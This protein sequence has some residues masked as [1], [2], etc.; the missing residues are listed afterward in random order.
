[1]L[2]FELV[3]HIRDYL[4]WRH[5]CIMVSR[6][7]LGG[8]LRRRVQNHRW[9]TKRRLYSYLKV[10]GPQFVEYT[11]SNFSQTVLGI[12]RRARNHHGC[13]TWMA[14]AKKQFTSPY[15]VGCG[16]RTSANIMD[17]SLCQVCR[18]NRRLVNCYMVK[19]YHTKTM[20]IPKSI[21]DG[22]PYHRGMECHLRFWRDIEAALE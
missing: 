4:P 8:A 19:V 11:W 15:C 17:V 21:I 7:W 3:Y 10:F 1:M 12:T 18:Y 14:A 13:L 5:R 9:R 6:E 2:P 16:C 20:G 22:I